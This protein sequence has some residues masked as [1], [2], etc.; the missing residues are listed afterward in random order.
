MNLKIQKVQ[1]KFVERLLQTKG[2]K[3]MNAFNTWK[4]IPMNMMKG[5]YKNYQKFYFSL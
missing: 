4:K 1:K 2:G 3:L 5:K